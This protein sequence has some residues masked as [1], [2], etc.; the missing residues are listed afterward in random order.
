MPL[1]SLYVASYKSASGIAVDFDYEDVSSDIEKKTTIFETAIGNGTFVQ[2]WGHTSGRFPMICIFHGDNYL[3]RSS[4]F[5][6][7]LLEP[8]I[9]V[10]THPIFGEINVIPTGVINRADPLIAGS[11]QIV[12]T[13][14]FSETIKLYKTGEI[15]V[16]QSFEDLNE[17]S[18]LSFG[19][20]ANLEDPGDKAAFRYGVIE[21]IGEIKSKLKTA[22]ESVAKVQQK[23]EDIAD[24]IL[25]GVDTA[26]GDPLSLA[27]QAQI[28]IGEPRR[29][30]EL[31]KNKIN[32]YQ[33][34]ASSIFEG[35]IAE[36]TDHYANLFRWNN[37]LAQA[38]LGNMSLAMLDIDYET[39]A[40]YIDAAETITRNLEDYRIWYDA[41]YDVLEPDT[42]EPSKV[43]TGDGMWELRS[44]MT[45]VSARL[46]EMSMVAKTEM[47]MELPAERTPIDLCYELYGTTDWE[48]FDKFVAQ[49]AIAGDEWYL[50]PRRRPIVWY[51]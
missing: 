41:S 33:D 14:M 19:D 38:I 32:A 24:S 18:Y 29:T 48:V 9:G 20:N 26:L 31:L 22:S 21:S 13:V 40:G 16:Y 46:V 1:R 8:G 11:G 42:L 15:D 17:V 36:A 28:L 34:M 6:N 44:I 30:K 2:D 50:I 27:R 25:R 10:L 37:L 3:E 47:Y 45:S 4:S 51:V 39:R 7:A 35:T 23:T 43:N 49:N 12:F 5:L